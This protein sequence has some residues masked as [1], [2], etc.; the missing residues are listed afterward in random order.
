MTDSCNPMDRGAWWATVH[1]ILQAR[2]LEWV[3]IFLQ[4][5][6]PTQEL[7]PGLLHYRRILY[8]LSYKGS[9][10][11]IKYLPIWISLPN[12]D[13][14]KVTNYACPWSSGSNTNTLPD[15]AICNWCAIP[16]TNTKKTR[17][18]CKH[19][20]SLPETID[21]AP[22]SLFHPLKSLLIFPL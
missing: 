6:F 15:S 2:I 14:N 5:I 19:H 7:N 3:A 18:S 9:P 10:L 12:I 20:S 16:D 8:Q 4:G 17:K 1:G 21:I 11:V 13:M 22:G